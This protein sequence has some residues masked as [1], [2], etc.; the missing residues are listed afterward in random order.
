MNPAAL[1]AEQ[2]QALQLGQFIQTAAIILGIVAVVINIVVKTRRKPPLDRELG[3][4]VTH[5][6]CDERHAR[7]AKSCA[8]RHAATDAQLQQGSTL[9]RQLERAIGRL[10]GLYEEM[11]RDR[12]G[13]LP[14]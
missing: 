11:R 10:E 1:S 2:L 13:A 9:F 14:Q 7:D 6:Q 12:N 5:N 3:S 4:F 8:E